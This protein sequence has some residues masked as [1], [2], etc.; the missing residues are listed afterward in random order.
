[1]MKHIACSGI[2]LMLLLGLAGLPADAQNQ[3]PST[4]QN[5]SSGSS[6][7]DYARQVR[8]DPGA[9]AKPKVFDN[10]NLPRED[11]LSVVG[12]TPASTSDNSAQSESAAPAAGET[13]AGTE[14][15]T[16]TEVKAPQAGAGTAPAEESDKQ[17]AWKQWGAKIAAQKD[18][19]DLLARG[20]EL[21]HRGDRHTA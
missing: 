1:M 20:T 11:K 3:D 13:K 6:L 5:P 2:G 19:I 10:D 18:Q 4:S 15:K 21:P 12:S 9:K 14:A 16:A 17:A 8:K 7:G